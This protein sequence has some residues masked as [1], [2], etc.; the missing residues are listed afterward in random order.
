M[1]PNHSSLVG[2]SNRNRS[3]IT[4]GSW[5]L[6]GVD[7]RKAL[8]RRYRDLCIAF[9]DD[10]GG[11]T[12]LTAPQEALIRQAAAVTVES[13]KLQGSI[14]RGEAVDHEQLVRLSNLQG[15]LLRQLG[16]KPKGPSKPDLAEYLRSRAAA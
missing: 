4:N 6:D 14:V 16:I 1:Q 2:T 15:R 5:L 10:L 11:E 7:N 9:A 8:G 3:A 12:R 13:E